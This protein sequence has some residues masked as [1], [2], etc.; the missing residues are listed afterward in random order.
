MLPFLS[1]L[2]DESDVV[3]L[4][5]GFLHI[6]EYPP[7]ANQGFDIPS[8]IIS[9]PD[10]QTRLQYKQDNTS[11]KSPMV[12]KMQVWKFWILT[13]FS[14]LYFASF[15]IVL[16]LIYVAGKKNNIILHRSAS[17]SFNNPWF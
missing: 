7:D 8:A 2:W 4:L 16:V 10:F 9:Y 3:L 5:Q 13:I 1:I 6:D 12:S 11:I 17:C 15:T 14:I